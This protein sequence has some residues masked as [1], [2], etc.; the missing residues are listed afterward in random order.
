M[1]DVFVTWGEY[2]LM[3]DWT[4]SNFEQNFLYGC[5]VCAMKHKTNLLYYHPVSYCTM[6]ETT[7][8][9]LNKGVARAT[10]AHCVSALAP[11][12]L[13]LAVIACD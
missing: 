5:L 4:P 10:E 13:C 7:D 8:I 2:F 1:G 3:N 11:N 12:L 9:S 6:M